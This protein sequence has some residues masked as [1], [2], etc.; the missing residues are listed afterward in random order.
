MARKQNSS[1]IFFRLGAV[2]WLLIAALMGIAHFLWPLV[3]E[4]HGFDMLFV[5]GVLA[6]GFLLVWIAKPKMYGVRLGF[7]RRLCGDA[8]GPR[9][10]AEARRFRAHPLPLSSRPSVPK[11]ECAE[12]RA[13]P[14]PT[15]TRVPMSLW[16]PG[17]TAARAARRR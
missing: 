10:D 2:F 12:G 7:V 3:S 13:E 9:G 14:G 15:S 1:A 16:V 4:T 17:L 8:A 11:H 5:I 6:V